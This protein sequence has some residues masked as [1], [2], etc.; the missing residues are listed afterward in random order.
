MSEKELLE[1][2]ENDLNEKPLD[3][4]SKTK[5]K[6]VIDSELDIDTLREMLS[7]KEAALREKIKALSPD[8]KY[9]YEL[10]RLKNSIVKNANIRSIG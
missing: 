9:V 4:D 7:K 5:I 2:I 8:E 3:F 6:M 10:Q 1:T